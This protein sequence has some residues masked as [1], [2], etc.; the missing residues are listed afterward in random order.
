MSTGK[1]LME[2][3]IFTDLV[4]GIAS[5]GKSCR[6]D[7]EHILVTDKTLGTDTMKKLSALLDE[8]YEASIAYQKHVSMSLPHA[9]GTLRDSMILQDKYGSEALEISIAGK[10]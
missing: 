3:T 7:R 2:T 4:D 6:L 1:I 8:E 5:S 9:L 10:K